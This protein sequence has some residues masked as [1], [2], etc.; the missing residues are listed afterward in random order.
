MEKRL[1]KILNCLLVFYLI[2]QPP[3]RQENLKFEL[4]EFFDVLFSWIPKKLVC[5]WRM[6][7]SPPSFTV[8]R[9]SI[10]NIHWFIHSFVV[11]CLLLNLYLLQCKH[12]SINSMP[13][14]NLF[15][16][17]IYCEM[18]KIYCKKYEKRNSSLHGDVWRYIGTFM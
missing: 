1:I 10:S 13:D 12:Q 16:H 6:L 15:C 14:N 17:G 4:K 18:C 11:V 8:H 9:S 2:T 7:F 3:T 5:K